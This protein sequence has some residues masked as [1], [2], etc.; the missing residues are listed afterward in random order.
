MVP[1]S[2]V[3]RTWPPPRRGQRSR[4]TQSSQAIPV[5]LR[6]SSTSS[7]QSGAAPHERTPKGKGRESSF[8]VEL[9]GGSISSRSP[10]SGTLRQESSGSEQEHEQRAWRDGREG[11]EGEATDVELQRI[12][13]LEVVEQADSKA[14]DG[15]TSDA[16]PPAR[17]TRPKPPPARSSRRAK[18]AESAEQG[19]RAQTESPP[20]AVET[21]RGRGTSPLQSTRSFPRPP[22]G[23]PV[24][25]NA[26]RGR[27]SA[28][29]GPSSGTGS[30]AYPEFM[31]VDQSGAWGAAPAHG[32]G[33]AGTVASPSAQ[34][35]STA[36]GS[37]G[38]M[39]L[40]QRQV[41]TWSVTS[42]EA[43]EIDNELRGMPESLSHAPRGTPRSARTALKTPVKSRTPVKRANWP[44]EKRLACVRLI[45]A[46][47]SGS[48]AVS[49]FGC[50]AITTAKVI[51]IITPSVAF[52]TAQKPN[53]TMFTP[54][55]MEDLSGELS[56]AFYSSIEVSGVVTMMQERSQSADSMDAR[57]AF[58][59]DYMLGHP[60]SGLPVWRKVAWC[61]ALLGD[62]GGPVLAIQTA[63]M[64]LYLFEPRPGSFPGS[65][66]YKERLQAPET[67]VKFERRRRQA[68]LNEQISDMAW[69]DISFGETATR[70]CR[71]AYLV[72]SSRSGKLHVWR[73][74]QS[75]PAAFLL[76]ASVADF[77]ID[78]VIASKCKMSSD[79][80]QSAIVAVLYC[81]ILDFVVF[82]V[83]TTGTVSL[84]RI[85][86]AARALNV[87]ISQPTWLDDVYLYFAT[88]GAIMRCLPE[89]SSEVEI[90]LLGEVE[91]DQPGEAM[92]PCVQL[93]LQD[94]GMIHITLK[95]G[96]HYI[97]CSSDFKASDEDASVVLPACSLVSP[98]SSAAQETAID[99]QRRY[100][101]H[102][103]LVGYASQAGAGGG[104]RLRF[105]L[106]RANELGFFRH[107]MEGAV[108]FTLVL[109]GEALSTKL[110]PEESAQ[111]AL[112]SAFA[113]CDESE[114]LHS[115]IRLSPFCALLGSSPRRSA[116]ISAGVD[117]A[118]SAAQNLLREDDSQ[119]AE[120]E[121]RVV[122]LR[123]VNLLFLKMKNEKPLPADLQLAVDHATQ[124][125]NL[126][127]QSSHV[128]AQL[129]AAHSHIQGHDAQ[130]LGDS[131]SEDLMFCQRLVAAVYLAER[132]EQ[133]SAVFKRMENL[134]WKLLRSM[135]PVEKVAET[136]RDA[137]RADA[138]EHLSVQCGESCPACDADVPLV[139]IGG[140]GV[141]RCR[142]GHI[143]SRCSITWKL[144][145]EARSKTCVGCNRKAYPISLDE[146]GS[147]LLNQ[148]LRIFKHCITCGAPWTIS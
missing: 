113:F 78:Y 25:S 80:T 115:I 41:E 9:P 88:P 22:P 85:A 118:L 52:A 11:D 14:Q 71:S 30:E 103:G 50:V 69:L 123:A 68:M 49:S 97:L 61:P 21:S 18:L 4:P 92:S 111:A 84:E 125:I 108:N 33:L 110:S 67:K 148:A 93:E 45:G 16:E 31:D 24:R 12:A 129:E 137:L 94:S 100:E 126:T 87:G 121:K 70:T 34:S 40:S 36:Q 75:G 147:E 98:F 8:F 26:T 107:S 101:F 143:W 109:S 48:L 15:P 81:G 7:S 127:L 57:N 79:G 138:R 1:T 23:R 102:Q 99:L 46:P 39:S 73:C 131:T 60:G 90:A 105:A 120:D 128:L 13:A 28:A 106:H 122:A 77:P 104:A 119:A 59:H 116:L 10:F 64:D 35:R 6:A 141:T 3:P 139:A 117:V 5:P 134:A 142:T 43:M 2:D 42:S 83:D 133:G 89:A 29:A 145:G 96:N 66:V 63:A 144:L 62:Q 56:S 38:K 55:T 72:G 32:P 54:G 132:D 86:D 112:A 37:Q 95:D 17:V 65:M 20:A 114:Q 76:Q 146:G 140:D 91:D 82:A 74:N 27:V 124:R 51:H 53:L 136:A 19:A 44:E 58:T 130:N 47:D 135:Y